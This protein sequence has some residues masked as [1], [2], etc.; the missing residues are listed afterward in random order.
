MGVILFVAF[1]GLFIGYV[2]VSDKNKENEK[3]LK[4]ANHESIMQGKIYGFIPTK[5]IYREFSNYAVYVDETNHQIMLTNLVSGIKSVFK[6]SEL[7]EC[8]ILEDGATI[9]SGGVGRAVVGSLIGGGIGAIVGA[10]TRDS[11]PIT[12]SLSVR[13]V[14]SNI[15]YPLQEIP[16]IGS[17]TNR[18]SNDEYKEKVQFAQ[19]IYATVI[20][21]MHAAKSD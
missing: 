8:S 13:I 4:T 12:L 19:E 10:T 6:F 15:Q 16:I 20:S 9:M 5:S 11:T 21:I 2:C 1:V 7:I 3:N 18:G 17:S 14:T